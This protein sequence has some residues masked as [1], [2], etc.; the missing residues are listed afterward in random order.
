M[1][2]QEYDLDLAGWTLSHAI[3]ISADGR[4]LAGS[5]HQVDGLP[6]S[7]VI[8]LPEPAS[9]GMLAAAAAILVLHKRRRIPHNL[10]RNRR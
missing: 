10:A 3:A 5:G 4:I 1:L 7:W 8:Q 2:V 9:M 6:R